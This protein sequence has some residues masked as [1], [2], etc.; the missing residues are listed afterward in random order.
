MAELRKFVILNLLG[1][2]K[3]TLSDI[4]SYVSYAKL[5]FTKYRLEFGSSGAGAEKGL[6]ILW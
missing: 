4:I 6:Q 3:T 1:T 5:G 2:G